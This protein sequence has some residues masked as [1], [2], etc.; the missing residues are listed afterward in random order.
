MN[1]AWTL[2]RCMARNSSGKRKL[3][4]ELLKPGFI[5]TDVGINLAVSPLKVGIAH[6]GRSS[7][8]G[9]RYVDH[10]EVV[11]LND[12]VQVRV[13]EVLSRSCAP[14]PKQHVFHICE[15]QRA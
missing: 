10:V 3:K 13:N 14:M 6:H 12:P 2:R 4:E 11:F 1:G 7:V 5:L 9:A 8:P 15:F